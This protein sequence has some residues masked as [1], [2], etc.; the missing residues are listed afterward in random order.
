MFPE[1][2]IQEIIGF[3]NF[4][5]SPNIY[6]YISIYIYSWVNNKKHDDDDGDDDDDDDDSSLTWNKAILGWF[7]LFTMIPG[8]GRTVRSL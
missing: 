4:D 3:D 1:K 5:L 7:L 2:P 8:F 6:I